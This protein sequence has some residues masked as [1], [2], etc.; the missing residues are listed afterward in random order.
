M[1]FDINQFINLYYYY[2]SKCGIYCIYKLFIIDQNQNINKKTNTH[3]SIKSKN[4]A[5]TAKPFLVSTKKNCSNQSLCIQQPSN[6]T[7]KNI[8]KKQ[9]KLNFTNKKNMTIFFREENYITILNKKTIK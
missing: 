5:N 4:Q 2:F 9:K 3:P 7:K 1:I 6:Q 8:K